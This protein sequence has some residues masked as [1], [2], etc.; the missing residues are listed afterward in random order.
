MQTPSQISPGLVKLDEK[1]AARMEPGALQD[2]FGAMSPA[3]IERTRAALAWVRREI[4]EI[5]G[6]DLARSAD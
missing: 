1:V 6:S 4:A 5:A 3:E 2:L